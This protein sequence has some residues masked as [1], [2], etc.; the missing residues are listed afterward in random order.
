MTTDAYVAVLCAPHHILRVRVLSTGE[1]PHTRLPA[2]RQHT[3][4]DLGLHWGGRHRGHAI[5]G[6]DLE[7]T[8]VGNGR[9]KAHLPADLVLRPRNIWQYLF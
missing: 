3:S 7:R 2:V 1:K 6:L 4:D 5:L 9:G 8:P